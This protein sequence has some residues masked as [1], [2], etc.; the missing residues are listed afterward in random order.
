MTA[1][2]YKHSKFYDVIRTPVITEKSSMQGEIGKDVF[3]FTTGFSIY[4]KY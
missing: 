1:V 4:C 3:N 2:S